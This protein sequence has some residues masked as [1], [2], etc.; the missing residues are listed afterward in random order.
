[1]N[2]AHHRAALLGA[3]LAILTWTSSCR[4]QDVEAELKD[5]AREIWAK[6]EES[7]RLLGSE[8]KICLFP[9]ITP[10]KGYKAAV[11]TKASDKILEEILRSTAPTPFRGRIQSGR[12]LAAL[13]SN[14]GAHPSALTHE[15]HTASLLGSIAD[16]SYVICGSFV[17]EPS[18]TMKIVFYGLI[19]GLDQASYDMRPYEIP[20]AIA[21]RDRFA[22]DLIKASKYNTESGFD[23]GF[24]AVP[25]TSLPVA[26]TLLGYVLE[27][28][29]KSYQRYAFQQPG[30]V[31]DGIAFML[32]MRRS[33]DGELSRLSKTLEDGF[34]AAIGSKALASERLDKFLGFHD[35]GLAAYAETEDNVEPEMLETI[36]QENLRGRPVFGST[37][38]DYGINGNKLS[39]SLWLVPGLGDGLE[40]VEP[41][42]FD[43]EYAALIDVIK[44][45]DRSDSPYAFEERKL[46]GRAEVD[47]L[48]RFAL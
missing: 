24:G 8:G 1:M 47:R 44:A 38:G 3:A 41:F 26:E 40:F 27:H 10:A 33:G 16:A 42:Q 22:L 31:R 39:V 15:M 43:I 23:V 13:L 36:S 4:A 12:E 32:P 6:A 20:A 37:R 5:F 35:D 29:F 28:R 9:L 46:S 45:H 7:T 18:G 2:H 25:P 14:R 30:I 17:K 11:A 34:R 48:M 21:D 19:P